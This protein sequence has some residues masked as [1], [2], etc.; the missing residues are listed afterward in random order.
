M[1]EELEQLKA[2]GVEEMTRMVNAYLEIVADPN[3]RILEQMRD[4]A[5]ADEAQALKY[6]R[7]K[8]EKVERRCR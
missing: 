4:I 5:R 8:V 3:Y 1:D 7:A 2:L 6:E